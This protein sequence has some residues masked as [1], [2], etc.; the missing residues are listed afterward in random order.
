MRL[1]NISEDEFD[2]TASAPIPGSMNR[3]KIMIAF[4]CSQNAFL[5]FLRTLVYVIDKLFY[6]RFPDKQI[7]SIEV[8]S[9]ARALYSVWN[10][11]SVF[12]LSS[13][14]EGG[15]WNLQLFR[16]ITSDS[17]VFDMERRNVLSRY[18]T[19]VFVIAT[20]FVLLKGRLF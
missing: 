15:L 1:F 13:D 14:C 17:C 9:L 2:V 7:V 10:S 11:V 16:S 12:S 19:T 4:R 18:E 8:K 20:T 3:K 6:T 5:L